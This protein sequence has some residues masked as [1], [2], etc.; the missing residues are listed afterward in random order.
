MQCV[1]AKM[2]V[3]GT[4]CLLLEYQKQMMIAVYRS[5]KNV[6][7]MNESDIVYVDVDIL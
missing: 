4:K 6:L 5:P 3:C 1:Q 7:K 2:C